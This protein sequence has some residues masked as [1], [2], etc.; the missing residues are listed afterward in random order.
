MKFL[1]AVAL[2]AGTAMASGREF[3]L[4]STDATQAKHNNL[5]LTAYHTGAG[6]NDAVLQPNVTVASNFFLNGT[7][8]YADLHTQYPWGIDVQND[9]N[10]AGEYRT[11]IDSSQASSES[12]EYCSMANTNT[13]AWDGITIN[14][15][16]GSTGFSVSDA[17]FTWSEKQGFGGWLSKSLY[18]SLPC[19]C[20]SFLTPIV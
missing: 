10:Y 1:A 17:K 2:L 9:V 15:G 8:A 4:K 16:E 11:Q 3:K 12:S 14:A 20:F 18:Y 5:Y 13:I 7:A 19:V 6:T